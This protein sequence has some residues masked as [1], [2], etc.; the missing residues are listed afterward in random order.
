MFSKKTCRLA[1]WSS[2][3]SGFA[4]N[5]L[6][7]VILSD[8]AKR[9]VELLDEGV[10]RIHPKAK[11]VKPIFGIYYDLYCP[12]GLK[13][14]F[15]TKRFKYNLFVDPSPRRQAACSPFFA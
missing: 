15:D 1:M 8:V 3:C 6:K 4:Q 7:R 11:I 2:V 9:G 14:T 10:K 13:V 12:F 5:I